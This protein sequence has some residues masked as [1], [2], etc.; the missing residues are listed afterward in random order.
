MSGWCYSWA[1]ILHAFVGA[2]C[3][4][5]PFSLFRKAI[6]DGRVMLEYML[7]CADLS[8]DAV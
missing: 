4:V 2:V 1:V 5:L 6:I 7:D 3:I 8:K